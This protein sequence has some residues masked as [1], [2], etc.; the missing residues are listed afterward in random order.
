M[1]RKARSKKFLMELQNLVG[2]LRKMKPG[3][4]HV[5]SVNANYGHYQIMIGPGKKGA[6]KDDERPIEIDGE[7]H[8]LFITPKEVRAHPSKGQMI[9][10]LK[11]TVI[12]R[13]LHVHLMDPMGDGQHLSD[14]GGDNGL[15][16]KEYINLAG[17]AGDKIIE[18][19]ESSDEISYDTYRI[20][21]ADIIKALKENK[22]KSLED[23]T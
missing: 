10:N 13:G 12:M 3:E 2:A 16:A 7:I 15:H 9:A 1:R 14:S 20:I 8:H 21:Q 6:A 5:L 22:R 4:T 23:V 11:D 19:I 18:K 17:H